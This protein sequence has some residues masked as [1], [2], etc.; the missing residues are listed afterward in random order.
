MKGYNIYY[1]EE[2]HLVMGEDYATS[3]LVE[4]RYLENLSTKVINGLKRN[5]AKRGY[6]EGRRHTGCDNYIDS[7]IVIEERK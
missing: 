6:R 1:I 2:H 3:L 7:R 4:R 5:L